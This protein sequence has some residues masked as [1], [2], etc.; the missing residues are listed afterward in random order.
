[1]W[2]VEYE[3]PFKSTLKNKIM[4][5]YNKITE[6]KE[7]DITDQVTNKPQTNHNQFDKIFIIMINANTGIKIT[8][9]WHE[10]ITKLYKTFQVSD[11]QCVPAGPPHQ[12]D[13][14]HLGVLHCADLPD[15]ETISQ[16]DNT[17]DY[18]TAGKHNFEFC[19]FFDTDF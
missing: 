7:I 17:A 2:S 16:A 3:L 8:K 13:G 4:A 14:D 5:K 6:N 11:A 12:H 10:F 9:N 15:D 1:M 19:N 18:S